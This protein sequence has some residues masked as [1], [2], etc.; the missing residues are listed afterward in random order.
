M[1]G[2]LGLF[3]PEG[4]LE[5]P[6]LLERRKG[7]FLVELAAL[8]EDRLLAE[9]VDAEERRAPFHGCLDES[10]GAYQLEPVFA[11]VVEGRAHD[12]RPYPH[13][14]DGLWSADA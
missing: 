12:L 4:R 11:E 9:V 3:S 1:L 8:A 5:D 13:G 7:G 14:G 10:G 2:G 6:D